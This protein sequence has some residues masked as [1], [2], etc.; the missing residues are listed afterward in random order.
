[1]KAMTRLLILV[2]AA[3]VVVS[4]V[5]GWMLQTYLPGAPLTYVFFEMTPVLTLLEIVIV[6]MTGV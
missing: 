5:F 1:M 2:A 4:A 3:F 6:I